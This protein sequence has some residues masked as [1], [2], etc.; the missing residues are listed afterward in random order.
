MVDAALL[1]RGKTISPV[2]RLE[3]IGAAWGTL[4]AAD[5]PD[6]EED[7]ALLDVRLADL[8]NTPQDQSSWSAD[9]SSWAGWAPCAPLAP[10]SARHLVGLASAMQ[11]GRWRPGRSA[12]EQ[13]LDRLHQNLGL[14][15]RLDGRGAHVQNPSLS[16]GGGYI[17]QGS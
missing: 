5:V 13:L 2:E 15:R 14:I 12:R 4:S 8:E 11:G 1:S 9:Q 17:K 6:T 3:L 16:D 7:K 10:T